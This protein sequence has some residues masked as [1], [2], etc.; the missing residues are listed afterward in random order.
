MPVE[1][2]QERAVRTREKI[3]TGAVDVLVS[4]GYAGF[5][6]ARVQEA[7]GVTRGA[8]THH[9][10][11]MRELA[12]A[13]IDHIAE[14]QAGEI[15]SV[16]GSGATLADVTEAIHEVTRRATFVAGLELWLAARTDTELRAA[17]QPG[18]HR[19]MEQLRS[20]LE[21]VVGDL[22]DES[23]EIFLDG[24]LSL[25]RGLAIGAVLRDRPQREHAILNAWLSS[26]LTV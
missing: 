9:F 21:P 20:I 25:L 15:R 26:Y 6:M 19:L 24:L 12:V 5:T 14:Q 4:H 1:P 2:R 11:S 22:D 23:F 18:A 16:S 17:L 3:L 8:L 7:A 10:G 13:A